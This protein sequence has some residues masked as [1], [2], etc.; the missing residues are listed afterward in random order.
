MLRSVIFLDLSLFFMDVRTNRVDTVFK[1]LGFKRLFSLFILHL[2]ELIQ[3][4]E[5]L[6]WYAISS[7]DN[8]SRNGWFGLFWFLLY[9]GSGRS[10][11]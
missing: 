2:G 3:I 5:V 6:S 9:Q 11:L 4:G 8:S 1:A 10:W 7:R